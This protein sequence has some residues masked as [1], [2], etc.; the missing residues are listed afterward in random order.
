MLSVVAFKLINKRNEVRV[1]SHRYSITEIWVNR[2]VADLGEPGWVN[3][4]QTVSK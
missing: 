4:G 3:R 2:E 1:S